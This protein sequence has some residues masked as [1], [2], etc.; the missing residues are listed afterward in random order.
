MQLTRT[1]KI[2]PYIVA[3]DASALIRF[4]EAGLGGRVGFLERGP[5]GGLAHAEVLIS[6]GLVMIGE[7]PPGRNPFPAMVHL[8][9]PDADAAFTRAVG[10]GATAVRPPTDVD[11][12]DRRGGVRDP[13]GNEWWFTR[14][15]PQ[16]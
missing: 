5:D 7:A 3:R 8:Y 6:D 4:L 16:P 12:G 13:W 9:V 10:A 11:D 15:R 2:A 14:P 1:P